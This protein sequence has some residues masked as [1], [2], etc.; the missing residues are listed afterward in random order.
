[1][2]VNLTTFQKIQFFFIGARTKRVLALRANQ[3]KKKNFF[4]VKTKNGETVVFLR[5]IAVKY[6]YLV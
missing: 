4:E 5:K 6:I 2:L 1:M 3:K